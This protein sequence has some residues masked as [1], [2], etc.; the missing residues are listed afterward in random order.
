MR[1]HTIYWD[2]SIE[3]IK[4]LRSFIRILHGKYKKKIIKK[5]ENGLQI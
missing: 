1:A 4:T 3:S 5:Y 2:V